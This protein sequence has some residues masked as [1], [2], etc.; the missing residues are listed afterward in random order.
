[1]WR[2][3]GRTETEKININKLTVLSRYRTEGTDSYDINLHAW[4]YSFRQI[5]GI[6][7]W[8]RKGTFTLIKGLNVY[9]VWNKLRVQWPNR[10]LHKG[11][12]VPVL[13]TKHHAMKA[14]WGNGGISTRILWPRHQMK[15]SGASRPSRFTPREREAG[16]DPEPFWTRF[17]EE[18][19][20]QPP[21]GI[22]P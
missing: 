1:M 4:I 11:K 6:Y 2:P 17:S 3:E 21:P 14:Y 20:S 22:E 8:T 9:E 18:K 5:C 7:L 19:N 13:L 15:V 12:V 10:S 16:W